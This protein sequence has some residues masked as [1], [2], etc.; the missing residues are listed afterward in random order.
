MVFRTYCSQWP[1]D[2]QRHVRPPILEPGQNHP[3]EVVGRY[4]AAL[5]AGDT[6]EI[7]ED[8]RSQWVLP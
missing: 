8:V 6:D 1:V 5:K 3:G 2:G 7:R 4:L